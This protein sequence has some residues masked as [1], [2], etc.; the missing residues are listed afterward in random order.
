MVFLGMA[1]KA[2]TQ[3]EIDNGALANEL[4]EAE[5][6]KQTQ[7]DNMIVFDRAK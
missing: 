1:R 3:D 6:R 5:K 7:E 2:K 4:K